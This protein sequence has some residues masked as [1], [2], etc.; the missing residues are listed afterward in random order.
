MKK[1]VERLIQTSIHSNPKVVVAGTVTDASGVV[2]IDW[3]TSHNL[4]FVSEPIVIS[5]YPIGVATGKTSQPI[6]YHQEW[7]QDS[8]NFYTGMKVY[9]EGAGTEIHWAVM[10]VARR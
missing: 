10:G 2:T 4:V 1:Q 7:I 8:N 3:S 9:S 6:C 5:I